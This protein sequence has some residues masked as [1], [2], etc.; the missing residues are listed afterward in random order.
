MKMLDKELPELPQAPHPRTP[1][2]ERPP[3]KKFEPDQRI[4]IGKPKPESPK[5]K[6]E[7]PKPKKAK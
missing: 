7:K 3:M 1:P 2:K 6:N 4:V 5:N